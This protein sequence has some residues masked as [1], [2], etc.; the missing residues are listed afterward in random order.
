MP[1]AYYTNLFPRRFEQPHVP[2]TLADTCKFTRS[3]EYSLRDTPALCRPIARLFD[4]RYLEFKKPEELARRS[5]ASNA[6]SSLHVMDRSHTRV[7]FERRWLCHADYQP[8][9]SLRACTQHSLPPAKSPLSGTSRCSIEELLMMRPA[10]NLPRFIFGARTPNDQ[11]LEALRH[12]TP[13]HRRNLSLEVLRSDW[14]SRPQRLMYSRSI[15]HRFQSLLRYG[16]IGEVW[17]C[18]KLVLQDDVRP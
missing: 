13:L 7:S 9:R 8:G 18:L 17:R 16:T 10:K 11:H 2:R 12:Q 4:I 15:L 1:A 3:Y 6:G 5:E 14:L